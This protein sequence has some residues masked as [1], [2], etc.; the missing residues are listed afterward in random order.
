MRANAAIKKLFC[1]NMQDRIRYMYERLPEKIARSVNQYPARALPWLPSLSRPAFGSASVVRPGA[2][3]NDCKPVRLNSQAVHRGRQRAI[4]I[5]FTFEPF[6]IRHPVFLRVTINDSVAA[7]QT[8]TVLG[9]E[10][11]KAT[12]PCHRRIVRLRYS[13]ARSLPRLLAN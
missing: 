13:V 5:Y 2:S 7:F 12:V 1:K 10:E 11:I 8:L 9:L 3:A 4:E 6:L